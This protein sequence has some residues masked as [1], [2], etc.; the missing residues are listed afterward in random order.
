[1][2]R[3]LIILLA[4]KACL[5]AH[6]AAEK[7]NIVFLLADDMNRDTWGIYGSK[8]CKTPNIDKLAD[9][10][11]KFHRAY[12]SVAMCAPF[13]QELYSGR[14][15]W[16][17]GTLANHSRSK[18]GTRSLPHYLKPLGYRVALSGKSHVGPQGAYPFEILKTKTSKTKDSNGAFIETANKFFD[19]CRE[20]KTPFCL[21]IASNDGHAPFTTG[22]ASQYDKD[23]LTIPPYWLDT[24]VLRE[25]L[26]KYYAEITNFDRLVGMVR[27][28]LEKKGLWKNTLF[29]VCSEQSVQFP[30]A[31]WTCY[32]NGLHTGM[33]MSWPGVIKA[34]SQAGTLIS[35]ADVAPT[36]VDAAG[37]KL[38]E[39][40]VDGK[41]FLKTLR[42]EKQVLHEY[43]FGAFTNCNISANRD[44]IFPIRSIRSEGFSLLYN[45]NYRQQTSNITLSTEGSPGMSWHA[46]K[47]KSEKADALI[48]KLHHRPEFELYDL[49]NDPYE[50]RNVN[51]KPEYEEVAERMKKALRAKLKELGDSDPIATEKSLVKGGGKDGGGKKRKR[52]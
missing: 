27:A 9:D 39:G 43:V 7:P 1:M 19:E 40:D 38:K 20:K 24:P 4:L 26:V 49:K 12:C 42:G 36:F 46:L 32:D 22:D 10:G 28:S 35:M 5:I 41:S 45:P 21:F 16:R 52:K 47:G 50:L 14:S 44:R 29:V 34:G 2:K 11:M 15:P 8:D 6:T 30:F 3:F 25:H 13:R 51:G 31:K 18:A 48:R 23:K 37:G 17:T 33:V